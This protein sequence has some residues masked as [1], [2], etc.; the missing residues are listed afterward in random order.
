MSL[1]V[2][3]VNAVVGSINL[4]GAIDPVYNAVT[5]VELAADKGAETVLMPVTA[6]KQLNELPD[7]LVTR[8]NIVYYADARDALL[9]AVL[10]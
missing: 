4:G 10:E 1:P 2:A 3:K 9:K 7:E 8:V 6:R 5:I